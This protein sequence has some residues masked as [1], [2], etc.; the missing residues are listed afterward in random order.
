MESGFVGLEDI[1]EV[2]DP[3][4]LESVKPGLETLQNGAIRYLD[5]S[6]RLWMG[7]RGEAV[8]NAELGAEFSKT[9]VVELTA[10]VRYKDAEESKS[11]DY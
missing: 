2:I 11:A 5:F 10:V 1:V 8:I 7:H 4:P 6:I 3:L 9:G